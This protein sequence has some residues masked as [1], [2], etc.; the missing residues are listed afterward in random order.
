MIGFLEYRPRIGVLLSCA[1]MA[2]WRRRVGRD[3]AVV[4]S[5]TVGSSGD[6]LGRAV[7]PN[8][9]QIWCPHGASGVHSCPGR[10][11]R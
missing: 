5:R 10:T 7:V 4:Q 9:C 6:I 11:G 8:L 3:L 1:G 2:A